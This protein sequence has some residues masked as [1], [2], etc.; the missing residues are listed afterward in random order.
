MSTLNVCGCGASDVK[1][2]KIGDM[3]VI[4]KLDV[5]PLSGTTFKGK[6]ECEFGV[7]SGSKSGAEK[8]WTRQGVMLLLSDRL[9]AGVTECKKVCSRLMCVRSN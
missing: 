7:V 4:R 8:G 5:L 1:W 9:A 3:F 6:G 2:R